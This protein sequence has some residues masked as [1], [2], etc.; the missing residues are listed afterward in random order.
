MKQERLDLLDRQPRA[1]LEG[2][3]DYINDEWV[4]FTEDEAFPLEQFYFREIHIL[5]DE[6][7][8]KGVF[9]EPNRVLNEEWEYALTGSEWIKVRKTLPYSL[10]MLMQELSDEAF[11]AFVTN[12]NELGFS[13]YDSLYCYNQLL[14]SGNLPKDGVNFMIFDNGE[15]ICNI[16][17]FFTYR[18][19]FLD[20]FEFTLNT[21]KRIILQK[22]HP[23]AHNK[24]EAE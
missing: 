13:L 2:S 23:P 10:K 19:K 5:L 8:K 16:Q 4:F 18:D 15:L 12:L 21:N 3:I 7:W 9:L 11:F 6:G 17:H 24:C 1:F 14:F 20:R 22:V